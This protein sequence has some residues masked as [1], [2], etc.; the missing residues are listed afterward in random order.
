MSNW[1]P[2]LIVRSPSV[3]CFGNAHISN[4]TLVPLIFSNCKPICFD[5]VGIPNESTHF[6]TLLSQNHLKAIRGEQWENK[7]LKCANRLAGK[8][9][10]FFHIPPSHWLEQCRNTSIISTKKSKYWMKSK[11]TVAPLWCPMQHLYTC[12]AEPEIQWTHPF[13]RCFSQASK[14]RHLSMPRFF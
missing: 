11:S 9:K 12:Q 13:K 1:N 14:C 10:C 6:Q 5:K 4:M 8:K 2:S 7:H 3:F